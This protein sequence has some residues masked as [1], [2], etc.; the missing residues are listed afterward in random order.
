MTRSKKVNEVISKIVNSHKETKT[1][2]PNFM[3]VFSK[4]N[5]YK[6]R[7]KIN[8]EED[9]VKVEEL[10]EE[11]RIGKNCLRK[12][13]MNHLKDLMRRRRRCR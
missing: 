11:V 3:P 7:C 12:V 9:D 5:S 1:K 13:Q 8:G 6:I 4:V 10:N 2:N